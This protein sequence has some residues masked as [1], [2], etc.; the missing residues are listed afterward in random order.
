MFY[1]IGVKGIPL[2]KFEELARSFSVRPSLRTEIVGD[3][4]PTHAE[5]GSAG[6]FL[7]WRDEPDCG[8]WRAP[9][10]IGRGDLELLEDPITLF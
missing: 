10:R 1:A 2:E 6:L 4:P 5:P 8:G 9:A 7:A 3:E